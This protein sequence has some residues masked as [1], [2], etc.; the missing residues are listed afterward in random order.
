MENL[1]KYKILIVEDEREI[2]EL[3]SLVLLR[4]GYTLRSAESS[5]MARSC[6]ATESYDLIVLDW[7]LPDESG[8]DL[9]VYLR[10]ALKS[11]CPPI[12]MV[13]AKAD[14]EDIVHGLDLGAD[15]YVT[16]PFDSRVLV[17]RISALLRRLQQ[18]NEPP[19]DHFHFGTLWVSQ[20]KMQV[21]LEGQPVDLTNTEFRLLC[22]LLANPNVVLTREKILSLIQG[23]DVNV[24][25]RTVD[26]HLFSLRKKLAPWS[27]SIWTVRGV[28]YRFTPES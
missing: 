26:T 10:K 4:Q 14:P 7:M 23:A 12:L 27:E 24:I 9:L 3:I 11:H 20:Q 25:G 6:L 2:R 16:K 17:S 28:G 21:L 13:T 22:A 15:D 1:T 19:E 18:H 8:I 5:E